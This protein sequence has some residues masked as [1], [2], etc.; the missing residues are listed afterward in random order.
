MRF[1][2]FLLILSF[3]PLLSSTGCFSDAV[4]SDEGQARTALLIF[5]DAFRTSGQE[6]AQTYYYNTNRCIVDTLNEQGSAFWVE[7]PIKD[8]VDLGLSG[9][10]QGSV[11]ALYAAHSQCRSQSLDP[12][13]QYITERNIRLCDLVHGRKFRPAGHSVRI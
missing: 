13:G 8:I 10:T 5:D 4:S 6:F 9:A 1:K 12:A 7:N 3:L 2:N 11:D